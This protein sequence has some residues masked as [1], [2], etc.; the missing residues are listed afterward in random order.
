LW[1]R[2]QDGLDLLRHLGLARS[3]GRCPSRAD[4]VLRFGWTSVQRS[5][6]RCLSWKQDNCCRSSRSRDGCLLEKGATRWSV[7]VVTVTG[8]VGCGGANRQTG[9]GQTV[10]G[11]HDSLVVYWLLVIL[12]LL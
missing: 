8:A 1:V 6:L 9:N 7:V 11:L 4:A 10:K 12:L 5:R 2:L 3:C